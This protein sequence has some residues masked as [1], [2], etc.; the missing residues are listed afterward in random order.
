M[1]TKISMENVY[2]L[3]FYNGSHRYKTI[4]LGQLSEMH[5]AVW[6]IEVPQSDHNQRLSMIV[7]I[8]S[9]CLQIR[10]WFHLNQKDQPARSVN[11]NQF[12]PSN[13]K[14]FPLLFL[15]VFISVLQRFHHQQSQ[16]RE[17]EAFEKT[18]TTHLRNFDLHSQYNYNE[19]ASIYTSNRIHNNPFQVL[20][21]GG[22]NLSTQNNHKDFIV[23]DLQNPHNGQHFIRNERRLNSVPLSSTRTKQI[24]CTSSTGRDR[25]EHGKFKVRQTHILETNS[26]LCHFLMLALGWFNALA[27]MVKKS[28]ASY[29]KPHAG[30]SL[31]S[32]NGNSA[33]SRKLHKLQSLP[34]D[35]TLSPAPA[36]LPSSPN[37]NFR[38]PRN[39]E[40]LHRMS[41]LERRHQSPDPPPR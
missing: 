23:S 38:S 41:P 14:S 22:S 24:Q 39:H 10:K 36:S 18:R 35:P 12:S 34:K 26:I 40:V 4:N 31:L 13:M 27:S 17:R 32:K 37:F 33:N 5:I 21:N 25:D 8:V 29:V 16:L 28:F 2:Y 15:I 19:S 1:H 9:I 6:R 11:N 20:D 30:E 7:K 3:R